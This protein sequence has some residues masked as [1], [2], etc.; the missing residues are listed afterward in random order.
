M[1]VTVVCL[2]VDGVVMVGIVY[3][4]DKVDAIGEWAGHQE[5]TLTGIRSEITIISLPEVTE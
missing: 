3:S 1:N 2:M 5:V 4:K